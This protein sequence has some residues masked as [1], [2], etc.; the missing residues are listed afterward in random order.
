MLLDL[1]LCNRRALR[2]AGFVIKI[3]VAK[4]G[5]PDT[6]TSVS[7]GLMYSMN[8]TMMII[9]TNSRIMFISPDERKSATELT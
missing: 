3:Y 4:N 7:E 2:W 8:P 9:E 6:T 1:L 5:K